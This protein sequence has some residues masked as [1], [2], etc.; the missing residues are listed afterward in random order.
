MQM[1]LKYDHRVQ[2]GVDSQRLQQPSVL[3]P[4]TLV[5]SPP[6]Y[7]P[8]IAT[9][10]AQAGGALVVV[11]VVVVV[12]QFLAEIA[13]ICEMSAT[14]LLWRLHAL[15]LWVQRVHPVADWQ[16]VQH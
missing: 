11:V 2:P 5:I 13:P 3:R 4:A 1:L 8:F 6:E 9:L 14:L 10:Q 15:L 7:S 16:K 12:R